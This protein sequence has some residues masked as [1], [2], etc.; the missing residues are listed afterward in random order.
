M[1]RPPPDAPLSALARL[2]S[3]RL[4]TWL[5]GGAVCGIDP[6]TSLREEDEYEG[7]EPKPSLKRPESALQLATA[8]PIKERATSC[9]HGADRRAAHMVTH[10][11]AIQGEATKHLWSKQ[12]VK[13]R[14]HLF[15][16]ALSAFAVTVRALG[17]A[18][19]VQ[20]ARR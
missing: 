18:K 15:Y 10:S 12:A 20:S 14:A 19:A 2:G 7:E 6:V 16:L 17:R 11:H 1:P 5:A 3:G 9:G 13:C 8:L 4:S